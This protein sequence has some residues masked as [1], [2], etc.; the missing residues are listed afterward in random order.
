MLVPGKEPAAH[1]HHTRYRVVAP[2]AP[3]EGAPGQL[4]RVHHMAECPDAGDVRGRQQVAG[5]SSAARV[6]LREQ[7]TCKDEPL[8]ACR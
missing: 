8:R 3:V 4:P 5:K 6:A 7:V 2:A 1:A